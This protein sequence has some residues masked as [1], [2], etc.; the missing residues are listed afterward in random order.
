VTAGDVTIPTQVI[1]SNQCCSRQISQSD[2]SIHIKLNYSNLVCTAFRF[3]QYKSNYSV[4]FTHIWFWSWCH[5]YRSRV[6]RF[7]N[8]NKMFCLLV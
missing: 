7:E 2:C 1:M 4:F 6:I 8:V 5:L 3:T